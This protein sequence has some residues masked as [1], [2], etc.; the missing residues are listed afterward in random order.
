MTEESEESEERGF[1]PIKDTPPEERRSR[2]AKDHRKESSPWLVVLDPEARRLIIDVML[3]LVRG[4]N[5]DAELSK[6]EIAKRAGVARPTVYDHIEMLVELDVLEPVSEESKFFTPNPD[7]DLLH[8][9]DAMDVTILE[10][11]D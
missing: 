3:E 2:P 1:G 9:V 10:L 4:G 8:I 6:S 5:E 11:L 7:S